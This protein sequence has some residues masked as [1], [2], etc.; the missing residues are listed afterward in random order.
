MNTMIK[1]GLCLLMI[2]GL[3]AG[4]SLNAGDSVFFRDDFATLDAWKPMTI[5]GIERQTEYAIQKEAD[6]STVLVAKSNDSASGLVLK[7]TFN[8]AEYPILRWRW[9]IENVYARGNYREKAG[10]DYPMRVYVLFEF[11]PA[12]AS[13]GEKIRYDF[14]KSIY[15][16]YPPR[17]IL[18]YIWA[19]RSDETE[20]AASPYT[21]RSIMIPLE[22]GP[23][24]AGRWMDETVNVLEDY[25][26]FFGGNPPSKA[27]LAIMNDSD[28]T[29]ERST[30]FLQFI[31][32]RK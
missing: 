8:A 16:E 32:V 28:N 18:N 2:S 4:A 3:A 22:H 17:R 23:Q 1:F 9:K 10:D 20:P 30:S 24:N 26:R 15:G 31:E 27:T 11:D 29:K 13:M 12:T 21:N 14:L 6:G 19:N 25:H 7:R 5:H